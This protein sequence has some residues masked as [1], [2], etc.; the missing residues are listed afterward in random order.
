[1]CSELIGMQ[2]SISI[3]HS[4]AACSSREVLQPLGFS[5]SD[6]N[7]AYGSGTSGLF[8]CL[9]FK[10]FLKSLTAQETWHSVSLPTYVLGRS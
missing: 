5:L 1:M 8:V 10:F 7:L 6:K 2:G 3:F 9:T 4:T